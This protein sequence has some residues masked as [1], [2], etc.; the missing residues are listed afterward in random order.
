M[1]PNVPAR[2]LYQLL[3]DLGELC[4][5][6]E[7]LLPAAV[8]VVATELAHASSRLQRSAHARRAPGFIGEPAVHT[9]PGRVDLSDPDSVSPA[10][11]GVAHKPPAI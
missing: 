6:A 3:H 10:E 5:A 4:T 9:S 11:A 2:S 7:L 8:D 1:S